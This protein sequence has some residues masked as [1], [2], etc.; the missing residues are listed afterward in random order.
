MRAADGT[1]LARTLRGEGPRLPETRADVALRLRIGL[2]ISLWFFAVYALSDCLTG[3]RESHISVVLPLDDLIPF[4]PVLAPVYL[5]ISPL[6]YLPLV[7]I[8][9]ALRLRVLAIGFAIEIAL[10]GLVYLAL[11][12]EASPVPPGVHGLWFSALDSVNLEYNSLPSL[13]VA[14]AITAAAASQDRLPPLGRPGLWIWTG[15]VVL[16]TLLVK[17]H[18]IADVVAGMALAGITIW[19]II[20]GVERNLSRRS[21]TECL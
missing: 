15:L 20:P 3:L 7:V 2:A 8:D 4:L 17:Q 10:A 6:L 12:V 18:F 1:G 5:S 19:V 13:H 14:L 11:P 16:S 21:G 9:N